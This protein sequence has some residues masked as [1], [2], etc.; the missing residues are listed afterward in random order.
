[1]VVVFCTAFIMFHFH[2]CDFFWLVC[3]LFF[4]S[5]FHLIFCIQVLVLVEKWIANDIDMNHYFFKN[6]DKKNI[7]ATLVFLMLGKYLSFLIM[8][9]LFLIMVNLLQNF[10]GEECV[11]F[12]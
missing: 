2:T 11:F 3:F 7:L 9:L 8:L 12:I 1:M 5:F 10:Y 4:P 6:S